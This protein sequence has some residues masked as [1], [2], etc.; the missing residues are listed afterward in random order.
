MSAGQPVQG[1]KNDEELVSVQIMP[2]LIAAGIALPPSAQQA[3]RALV[4]LRWLLALDS[5]SG[6]LLW[7]HQLGAALHG[8]SPTTCMIDGRQHVLVPAGT[9]LTA[10]ALPPN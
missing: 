8:T 2:A 5:R 1:V 6:K 7:H 10:W 4:T 9:T 3:P